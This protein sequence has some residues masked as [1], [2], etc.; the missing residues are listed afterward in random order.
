MRIDNGAAHL[1]RY[2]ARG[3]QQALRFHFILTQPIPALEQLVGGN[4]CKLP[5]SR[6]RWRCTAKR[7]CNSIKLLADKFLALYLARRLILQEL[8]EIDQVFI[9]NY[10]RRQAI[11]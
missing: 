1:H 3:C 4:R 11:T 10:Q 9:L 7:A 5:R 6:L 2:L 8:P